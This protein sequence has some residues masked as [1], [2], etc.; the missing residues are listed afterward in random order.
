MEFMIIESSVHRAPDR[1]PHQHPTTLFFTALPAAQPT[2][3]ILPRASTHLNPDLLQ[4]LCLI[5]LYLQTIFWSPVIV[6]NVRLD[7]Q[8]DNVAVFSFVTAVLL[9]VCLK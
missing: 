3:M 1:Q 9:L 6:Q 5:L 7:V 4:F 8:S 2:I